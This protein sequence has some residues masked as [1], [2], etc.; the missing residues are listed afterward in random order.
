M[1]QQIRALLKTP[2]TP[3]VIHTS[4]GREYKVATMDHAQLSPDGEM[5]NIWFDNG[6]GVTLWVMHITAVETVKVPVS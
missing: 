3:F 4:G 6:G 2:F 5:V 1:T